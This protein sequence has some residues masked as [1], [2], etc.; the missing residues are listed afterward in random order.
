HD[1]LPISAC[2]EKSVEDDLLDEAQVEH[3]GA[4]VLIADLLRADPGD[5]FYDAKVKTLSEYIRHHV[6]EEEKPRTGIFAKAQKAG[7]DMSALGEK[8]QARKMEL[9]AQ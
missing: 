4:K 6:A 2:R 8:L 5:A 7:V 1:A 9:M 3:D